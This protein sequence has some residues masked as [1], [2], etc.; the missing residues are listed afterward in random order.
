MNILGHVDR[1]R[2]SPTRDIAYVW[3]SLCQAAVSG[4]AEQSWDPALRKFIE[5]AGCTEDDIVAAAA[6]YAGMFSHVG[7]PGGTDD[8]FESLKRAG[9]FD[10][11]QAAQVAVVYSLGKV[12]TGAWLPAIYDVYVDGEAPPL[13]DS[14]LKEMAAKASRRMAGYAWLRRLRRR[15]GTM[16]SVFSVLRSKPKEVPAFLIGRRDRDDTPA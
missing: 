10:T 6:A 12:M 1:R 2:Y 11:N 5:S 15:L 3:P 13:S 8:P 4:L 9:F 7:K 14:Q 16:A